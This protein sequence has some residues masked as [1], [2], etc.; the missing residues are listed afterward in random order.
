MQ[1]N[2]SPCVPA[3]NPVCVFIS[4]LDPPKTQKATQRRQ[5]SN[6]HCSTALCKPAKKRQHSYYI[7]QDRF[8]TYV[9]SVVSLAALTAMLL[10]DDAVRAVPA[11][12]RFP[13]A[14]VALDP[15]A[16]VGREDGKGHV[17]RLPVGVAHLGV[18]A[19]HQAS[20]CSQKQSEPFS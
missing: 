11:G 12:T 20:T 5:C 3:E 16:G 10:A 9:N 18:L 7:H 4:E 14:G 19:P 8:C 15:E 6:L 13:Q 17:V 1:I 2:K